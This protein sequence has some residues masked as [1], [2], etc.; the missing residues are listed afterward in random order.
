MLWV[1]LQFLE[2]TLA[3]F[4]IFEMYWMM[5]IITEIVVIEANILNENTKKRDC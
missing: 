1:F 5:W 4:K 3:G 2:S